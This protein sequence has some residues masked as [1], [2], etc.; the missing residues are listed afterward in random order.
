MFKYESILI[1]GGT[2][3]FGNEFVKELIKKKKKIKRLIIFSR[4]EWKQSEMAKLYP[5]KK[6]PFIRFFLGDVRDYERVKRALDKI[7]LIIH[8]AALKQVPAA[9]YNPIEFIKTNIL[10]AQNIIEAAIEKNVKKVISLSTDKAAAPLNL[11]GATKLC[12]DKLMISANNYSGKKIFSVCRYGNVMGS[13]GSLIPLL[14]EQKNEGFFTLTNTQMTRFNISLKEST[15]LVFYAIENSLGGEIFVPKI[16]SY[17]LIDVAKAI[18]ANK[19][20]KI[21]GIR[22]GEKMHEEMF[23]FNDS[24][25]AIENKKYFILLPPQKNKEKN[26]Y[27]KTHKAKNILKPFNYSSDENKEFLTLLELKKLINNFNQSN[28]SVNK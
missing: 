12:S 11:Y 1:T 17:K 23:T 5:K 18:D 2:G 27:L 20:I 10:G 7:D 22:P 25:N 13:R 15:D 4:D 16:P 8:A 21:I 19:K 9:E 14:L 3:S 6:Y 28:N 26:K 24:Y